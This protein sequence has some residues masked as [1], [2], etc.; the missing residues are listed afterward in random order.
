MVGD[1][2]GFRCFNVLMAWYEWVFSGVGI[3]AGV[4]IL[5][6]AGHKWKKR[7]LQGRLPSPAATSFPPRGVETTPSPV[8]I[9]QALANLS[10]YDSLSAPQKYV[11]LPVQWRLLFGSLTKL[12]GQWAIILDPSESGPFVEVRIANLPPQLKIAERGCVVWVRGFIA[13][14]EYGNLIVVRDAEILRIEDQHEIP[15][16]PKQGNDP[17]RHAQP[18]GTRSR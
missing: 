2:P 1:F 12:E 10:P 6:W 5:G 16:Q 15:R 4:A 7:K 9:G 3:P 17:N 13:Y 11:G 18:S 14:I 8:Q